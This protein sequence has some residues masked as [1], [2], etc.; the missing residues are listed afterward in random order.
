MFPLTISLLLRHPANKLRNTGAIHLQNVSLLL[1]FPSRSALST[2]HSDR[3]PYLNKIYSPI[4]YGLGYLQ[5]LNCTPL[6]FA[7]RLHLAAIEELYTQ[8]FAYSQYLRITSKRAG[9]T[10]HI[11]TRLSALQSREYL[12]DT[13][14]CLLFLMFR[15]K[16]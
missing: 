5:Y 11:H 9:N 7:L 4:V 8:C 6:L 13:T 10:I 1:C 15:R 14:M 12:R 2:P 3:R 16:P